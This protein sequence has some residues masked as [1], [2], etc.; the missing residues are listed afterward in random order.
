MALSFASQSFI[1]DA[2]N[3]FLIIFEDQYAVGDIINLNEVG[4]MVENINL[5]ITQ[6][7]DAEGRLIT[8]PNSEVEIVANLSSQWSRADLKIPFNY[9]IDLDR[10]LEIITQVATEMSQDEQW[11]QFITEPPQILGVENFSD[12]GIIVRVFIKTEP[13][14]QWDVSREFRRRLQITLSKAGIPLTPPQYI[15]LGNKH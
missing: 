15:W 9:D 2:L 14:K 10:A 6:I 13:L 8:I 1:K 12:R 4:G 5:R 7:R 3:G 11:K